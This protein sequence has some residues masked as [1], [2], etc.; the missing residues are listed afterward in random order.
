MA[1]AQRGETSQSTLLLQKKK[2]MMDVQQQL[3][4]KKD[5]YRQRMQA[6]QERELELS[7]KQDQLR[8]RVQKFDKFLRDNDTKRARAFRKEQEEVKA[9]DGKVV[10]TRSLA[11]S[12][13][14]LSGARASVERTLAHDER[15][16]RYLLHVCDT[17]EDFQE[18]A[19]ILMRHA[20][21]VASSDDLL[22]RVTRATADAEETRATLASYVKE[23]QTETLVLNSEI[24]ALQQQLEAETSIVEQREAVINRNEG[25]AKE[26][27]R[28][29]GEITMAIQN[30]HAR[31]IRSKLHGS[32]KDA[33][34][35][36]EPTVSIADI[37]PLLSAIETRVT[38]LQ[39]VMRAMR[40][41]KRASGAPGTGDARAGADAA[42]DG[43]S[44]TRAATGLSAPTLSAS[45]APSASA[46]GVGGARQPTRSSEE[47]SVDGG[48]HASVARVGERVQRL[49]VRELGM[50]ASRASNAADPGSAQSTLVPVG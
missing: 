14:Q 6:C 24:A 43:V 1:S 30:I 12:L 21:L 7:S 28:E 18:I 32:A 9:H 23:A 47:A 2:E 48:R 3:D 26:R 38:D 34:A 20:T 8:D 17:T 27:S 11:D 5:E 50:P 29:L 4:R 44:G 16:E 41:H 15:Y 40:E 35:R 25:G 36:H 10:E 46:A 22:S 39:A 37:L 19:D 33:P 31:C 45:G 49:N 42:V 13:N